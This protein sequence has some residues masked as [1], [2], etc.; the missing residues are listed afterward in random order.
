M[1]SLVNVDREVR[2]LSLTD[3]SVINFSIVNTGT[4]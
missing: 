1:S 2:D 3:F 4:I